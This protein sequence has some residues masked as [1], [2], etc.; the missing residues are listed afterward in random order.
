MKTLFSYFVT[1]LLFGFVFLCGCTEGEGIKQEAPLP[2]MERFSFKGITATVT[3]TAADSFKITLPA[4]TDV[5]KLIAEFRTSP[6]SIVKI[7]DDVQTSGETEND[8]SAPVTYTVINADGK[9][10][11][12]TIVVTV[13][14][15]SEKAITAFSLLERKATI[16]GTDIT[17]ALPLS[18]DVTKLVATFT[19]SE[20]STVKVGT[21]LQTSGTT[22]NNFTQPVTYT[23][24]AEDGSTQEYTVTV[25][26]GVPLS[27][28]TSFS[29]QGITATATQ[30]TAD[31]FKMTLPAGTVVTKLVAIFS[32][33]PDNSIVKIGDDVQTSGT[34]ENDFSAPV[35]YTVINEDGKEKDYTVVVTVAK[36]SEKL[37]TAFSINSEVGT[38]DQTNKAIG[39][40]L[41]EN[42][43]VT[44]LVAT[45]TASA[46]STV[47]VGTDLQT[48]GTTPN[49]FSSPVTYTVTAED[50]STQDYTV[51]VILGKSPLNSITAFSINS[52]AGTIDQTYRTIALELPSGTDATKLV[53]TFT[54]SA[55]STVKVGT[56]LQTSG[57]TPNNFS[58]PVTYT[59]TA[60]DG[61]YQNYTVTVTF[62]SSEKAITAFSINDVAGTINPD[63][64]IAVALPSSG[65]DVTKLVATFTASEGATVKVGEKVQ[66]S[67]KTPNDFSSDV[68]YTVTAEDG[69]YQNY[70]VNV[71]LLSSEKAILSFVLAGQVKPIIGTNLAFVVPSD[72]NVTK[73]VATFMLT[74]KSTAT[75][76]GKLQVSGT[77]P[78]DFTHPVT[79]TITAEDGSTQD[80]IV[81][82]TVASSGGGG[83]FTLTSTAFSEGDTIPA[84]YGDDPDADFDVSPPLSW[85]NPP[86]GTV[87]YVLYFE[88]DG[89]VHWMAANIPSSTTSLEENVDLSTI[90]DIIEEN[91]DGDGYYGGPYPDSEQTYTFTLLA[92]DKKAAESEV[93]DDHSYEVRT[94]AGFKTAF[95]GNVL[96]EATLKGTFT[97]L[98]SE[99]DI[100]AFFIDGVAGTID[101]TYKTIAVVLSS[102]TDVTNLTATFITASE[103]STVKVG[104]DLQT[105]GT[106]P[107]NFSSPLTY[108]VT[109]EDGSTQDYVVTV[110]VRGTPFTF[111]SASFNDG[112]AIPAKHSKDGGNMSPPLSWATNP[113]SGAVVYILYIEDSNAPGFIHWRVA[114]IPSSTTEL[115]E[116]M[117]VSSL[118]AD[119]IQKSFA[120]DNTYYGPQ[121]PSGETH[122]YK[123]TLLAVDKKASS[124]EANLSLAEFRAQFSGNIVG[125]AT[126][127]G[128]F[129]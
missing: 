119:I 71:K 29:F 62:L 32:T 48:S 104:T 129:P 118:A 12:Y 95:S 41:P 91:S 40:A 90:T 20:K 93:I 37:I 13:V 55:K 89:K 42:T 66:E 113:P 78:N 9:E 63:R 128:T 109:A 86:S 115:T 30:S 56:D 97:P 98:S 112:G 27:E 38:I 84:K 45:F 24:T 80:Y 51:T 100:I 34:T 47:K 23:V 14:K 16:T 70:T 22:P 17:L 21:D 49:N 53:A 52:V 123:F 75:V 72:T 101:Q 126:L 127:T 82:V 65:T 33:S 44:K 1:A 64:T 111:T 46:K 36:S 108:T 61:T 85:T 43:D 15:S 35:T 74:D 103:K 3:Q 87:A 60:E 11:D 88:G 54:A 67:G 122:T 124:Y 10:K 121:P 117:D 110:S 94:L 57:T 83:T 69:T 39:V 116:G 76:G 73:L 4:G 92:L 99:N 18:T 102:G 6:N 120:E 79:Y 125:E 31:S 114:N 59:V 5:T 77:T 58:S 19:A 68:T 50:G 26:L 107:N 81:T 28:I 25:T 106:T 8:F 96:G 7:G 2:E 105:S